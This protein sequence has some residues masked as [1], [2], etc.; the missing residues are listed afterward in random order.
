MIADVPGVGQ[1][2][3]DHIAVFVKYESDLEEPVP[4]R[5]AP[6]QIGMRYTTPGSPYRNDMHMRPISIRTE[7]VP[8]DFDPSIAKTPTG[9][10]IALQKAVGKGRT[11]SSY[12]QPARPTDPRLS[13]FERAARH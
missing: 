5:P 12:R 7:H 10:S 11:P 2:L 4:E 3:R 1:N 13:L 6:L 8:V 9:F